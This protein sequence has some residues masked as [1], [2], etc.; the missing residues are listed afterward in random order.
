MLLHYNH[1]NFIVIYCY[2]IFCH[3]TIHQPS[4]ILFLTVGTYLH[5]HMVN[6]EDILVYFRYLNH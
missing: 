3:A 6:L 5:K 2:V 4:L 1:L